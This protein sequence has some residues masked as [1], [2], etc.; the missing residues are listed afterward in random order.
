M[1]TPLYAMDGPSWISAGFETGPGEDREGDLATG[2]GEIAA[3][4]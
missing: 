4:R 2:P 1:E 3:F